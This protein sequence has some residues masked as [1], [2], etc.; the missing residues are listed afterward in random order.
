MDFCRNIPLSGGLPSEYQPEQVCSK[1][2]SL[3]DLFSCHSTVLL[4]SFPTLFIQ[5]T[6][7]NKK[8]Q[9]SLYFCFDTFFELYHMRVSYFALFTL[10]F[11]FLFLFQNFFFF[12]EKTFFFF[13][14]VQNWVFYILFNSIQLHQ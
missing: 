8:R 6:E 4:S 5:E 14:L 11:L 10:F 3:D 12:L 13:V 1:L 9:L 2:G 7:Y